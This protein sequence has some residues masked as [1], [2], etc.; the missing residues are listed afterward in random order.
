MGHNPHHQVGQKYKVKC[1]D[2]PNLWKVGW[3]VW[4][5]GEAHQFECCNCNTYVENVIQYDPES[6]DYND[7][8]HGNFWCWKD[9]EQQNEQTKN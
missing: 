9:K 4:G 8:H 6:E 3:D 1:C 2:S 5:Y 7:I